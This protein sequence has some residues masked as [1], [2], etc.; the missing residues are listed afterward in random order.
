MAAALLA[1]APVVGVFDELVNAWC[2]EDASGEEYVPGASAVGDHLSA[3]RELLAAHARPV[4]D[5]HPGPHTHGHVLRQAADVLD[6]LDYEQGLDGDLRDEKDR[7]YHAYEVFPGLLRQR[8]SVCRA[9]C[10]LCG[11]RREP[12]LVADYDG[13]HRQWR[14][15]TC[16]NDAKRAQRF[17]RR[18]ASRAA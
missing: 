4:R 12:V 1:L 17:L 11:E 9:V 3:L 13:E 14:C 10:P 2:A 6:R 7:R 15:R 18:T 5:D 8:A 16:G